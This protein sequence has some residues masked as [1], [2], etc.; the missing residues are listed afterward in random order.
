MRRSLQATLS[1]LFLFALAACGG[2]GSGSL[3][4][5]GQSITGADQGDTPDARQA[6]SFSENWTELSTA[7]LW[8]EGDVYGRWTDQWNGYGSISVVG[9]TAGGDALALAPL[10]ATPADHSALVTTSVPLTTFS[11]AVTLTTLQQLSA[12]PNPWEVGWV[13]WGF[14]DNT[15]FY[16]FTPQP[17][18][19]ELSK[20]DPAYAGSQRFLA[21]GS[22]PKFPVGATYTVAIVQ[23]GATMTLSVNGTQIVQF[24]DKER[25]YLSGNLGLYTEESL[26]QYG[27]ITVSTARS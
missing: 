19:W 18:G 14:S 7:G 1:L 11:A 9:A 6:T 24:T 8:G 17:N 22:S 16:A 2:G 3:P 10:A 25:P 12:S 26:V 4:P 21:T 20:E 5:A 13:L 15:H 27:A 23:A